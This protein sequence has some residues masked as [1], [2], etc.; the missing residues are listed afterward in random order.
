MKGTIS[1]SLNF[2]HFLCK[3]F[4]VLYMEKDFSEILSIPCL[5][6][7]EAGFV[8]GAELTLFYGTLQ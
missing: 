1:G 4:H 8:P 2:S 3:A 5:C 7:Y 6:S